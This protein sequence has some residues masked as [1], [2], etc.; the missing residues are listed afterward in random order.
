MVLSQ[1]DLFGQPRSGLA[2]PGDRGLPAPSRACASK[3]IWTVAH[4]RNPAHRSIADLEA[5]GMVPRPGTSARRT[6]TGGHRVFA[7][8]PG[9]QVAKTSG[10]DAL[11]LASRS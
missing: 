2:C 5:T 6:G 1:K 3:P 4:R 7:G 8:N 10:R 9:T 11:Y